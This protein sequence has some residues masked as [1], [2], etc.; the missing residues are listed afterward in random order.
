M[1]GLE[2][3]PVRKMPWRMTQGVGCIGDCAARQGRQDAG[4]KIAKHVAVICG[5]P[6]AGLCEECA[7]EWQKVWTR[8]VGEAA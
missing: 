5:Y 1:S 7:A 2:F 4:R 8:E 3:V 6:V